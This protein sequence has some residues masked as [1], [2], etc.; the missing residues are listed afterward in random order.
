MVVAFLAIG[1]LVLLVC[2]LL[3]GGNSR[4]LARL[5]DLSGRGQPPRPKDTFSKLT[6]Q[7]LPKLG[8]PLAP[9]N[10]EERSRLK[11]R[12][13]HAGFYSRHAML[14]YL[15]VKMLLMSAPLVAA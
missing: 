10:E 3:T 12:L 11:A 6:Q 4:I 5:Q 1:S 13:V 8:A 14:L 15:G 7:T 9:T 2:V